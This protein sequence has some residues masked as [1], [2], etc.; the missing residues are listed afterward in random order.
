VGFGLALPWGREGRDDVCPVGGVWIAGMGG[1]YVY[2]YSTYL[3]VTVDVYNCKGSVVS[4][5]PVRSRG[6]P[7]SF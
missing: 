7:C 5:S 6:V 2:V 1:V 3:H 4:G